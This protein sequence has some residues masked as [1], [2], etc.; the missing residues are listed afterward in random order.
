MTDGNGHERNGNGRPVPWQPGAIK[1]KQWREE[2]RAEYE[3]LQVVLH[4]KNWK[5]REVD[6]LQPVEGV[7][8]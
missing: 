8:F 3:K 6:R 1:W 4:G 7:P 2:N 5:A